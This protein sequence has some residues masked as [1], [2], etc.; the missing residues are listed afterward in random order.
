[1]GQWHFGAGQVIHST[2]H[3]FGGQGHGSPPTVK[4]FY[5]YRAIA[6]ETITL[7]TAM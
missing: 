2:I 1:V 6:L 7:V 4:E 3:D 5:H